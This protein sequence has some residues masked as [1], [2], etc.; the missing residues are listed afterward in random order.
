MSLLSTKKVQMAH[1]M[2]FLESFYM[3][4]QLMEA[5]TQRLPKIKT[6]G[7][8]STIDKL[9]KYKKTNIHILFLNYYIELK[10][11]KQKKQQTTNYKPCI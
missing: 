11:K 7:L 8:N 10:K 2:I 9:L 4:A 1:A 6:I 5:I 3:L